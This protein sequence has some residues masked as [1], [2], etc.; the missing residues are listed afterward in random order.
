MY[1]CYSSFYN[2]KF[3]R[4]DR[5]P[6]S[7]FLEERKVVVKEAVIV[8]DRQTRRKRERSES[9]ESYDDDEEYQP[10]TNYSQ[11]GSYVIIEL[12]C[13]SFLKFDLVLVSLV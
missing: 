11:R 7:T 3:F 9:D 8:D 12:F 1:V 6:W 13:L 2:Y 4:F 10:P 5:S